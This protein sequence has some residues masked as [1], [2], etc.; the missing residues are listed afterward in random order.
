[1]APFASHASAAVVD[2]LKRAKLTNAVLLVALLIAVGA[3]VFGFVRGSAPPQES[4]EPAQRAVRV[5]SDPPGAS[6]RVDGEL[7]DELTPTQFLAPEGTLTLRLELEGYLP[8][9]QTVTLA[10]T[11]GAEVSSVLEPDP[12]SPNA[13]IGRVRVVFVPEDARLFVNDRE[14]G[15][16]SPLLVEGLALNREHQIRLEREGFQPL[17]QRIMLD[18]ADVLDLQVEMNES[19]ELGR[20]T[21]RS[22]PPGATVKVNGESLGETPIEELELAAGETYTIEVDRSGY[23]TW[24]RAILLRAGQTE[25]VVAQL[26]RRGASAAPAPAP[27]TRSAPAAPAA[28]AAAEPASPPPSAAPEEDPYE[29]LD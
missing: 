22:Q 29:L 20:F 23:R 17:Y 19:T 2:Q 28:P 8:Q 15:Q 18:N 6:I 13:P 9:E 1:M 10:G 12:E 16:G 27:R 14:Q 4:A 24:R 7:R 5:V 26:E 25:D 3:A 21:I 11:E